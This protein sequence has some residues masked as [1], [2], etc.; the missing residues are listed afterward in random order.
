MIERHDRRFGYGVVA[1]LLFGGL[2]VASADNPPAVRATIAYE[3][4][5]AYIA[6]NDGDYGA[7]GTRYSAGD[8]GQRANLLLSQ[9]TSLELT[10]GR[11]TAILLY[12]P[13]EVVTEVALPRDLQFRDTLFVSGTIVQHRYLFDGYRGSY[14]YRFLAGGAWN[15]EAGGSVQIRNAQVAFRSL[16][17]AQRAAQDDI[18]L[19]VAAKTRLRYQPNIDSWWGGLE[20][21][22]FS[23]FG[24][25]PGVRGAIYD[26]QLF[27]GHPVARGI[28]V[29]FGARLL[30][31]GANVKSKDIYNW[32]N[33][34]AFTAGVRISLDTLLGAAR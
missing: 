27:A 29:M 5:P 30:G 34:I 26:V 3:T 6:Q 25:V 7:T 22:G 24:L 18:G 21:D 12:A 15:L 16:D 33:F 20:A 8:V 10:R 32:A 2:R 1:A 11:H 19:V 28:D 9:R 23:T 13:F 14:L 31:G 17:G 4:G